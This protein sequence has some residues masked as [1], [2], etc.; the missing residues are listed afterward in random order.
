[1]SLCNG[2]SEVKDSFERSLS[3]LSC[4][5]GQDKCLVKNH[6]V[7][8]E[9]IDR[10]QVDVRNL[11]SCSRDV[12]RECVLCVDKE[13]TGKKLLNVV[14]EIRS[15]VQLPTLLLNKIFACAN[16][17]GK[18]ARFMSCTSWSTSC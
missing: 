8:I 4:S 6:G 15:S 7:D 11:V 17:G 13:E 16:H 1:M 9:A 10:H 2:K 14:Q 5:L 12:L 3:Y 18:H